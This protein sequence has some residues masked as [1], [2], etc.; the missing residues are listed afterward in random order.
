MDAKITKKRL[1]HLLSYDWIKIA[2][3]CALAVV[4][5]MLIFTTTA[6][7]ATSGQVFDI[8][9]YTGVSYDPDEIADLDRLHSRGAL[10]YDVL[11]LVNYEV[12]SASLGSTVFPARFAAGEGDVLIALDGGGTQAEDGTYTAIEGLKQFL[13]GY[14][15]NCLSLDPSGE[16]YSEGEGGVQCANYFALCAEYLSRFFFDEN[17]EADWRNGTLDTA[18]AR[19]AFDE[20]MDGDKRYRTAAKRDAAFQNEIARL[21][22][23]RTAYT[24][25]LDE[26]Q[27]ENGVIS[28]KA[29]AFSYTDPLTN[30]SYE[31]DWPF[32]FDLSGI[33]DITEVIRGEGED[34]RSGISMCILSTGNY[35]SPDL[36]YEQFTLLHYLATNFN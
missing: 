10:S 26:V 23:L 16:A 29:L 21:E 2:G 4:V 14:R 15:G 30:A 34:A 3:L 35:Q 8:Y 9:Y 7:R 1:G 20:R 25:V 18:A 33:A 19:A 11:D 27:K 6:T 5:W 31:F 36:R 17:G 32:A 28:V 22:N 24:F 12:P 13:Y